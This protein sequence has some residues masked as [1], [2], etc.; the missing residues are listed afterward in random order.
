MTSIFQQFFEAEGIV[1]GLVSKGGANHSLVRKT[2]S[3]IRKCL[4]GEEII[5]N[6]KKD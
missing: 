6:E 4:Q 5:Q 1:G 3:K 2:A